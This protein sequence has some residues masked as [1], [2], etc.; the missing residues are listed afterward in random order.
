MVLHR[1]TTAREG[2]GEIDMEGVV[3]EHLSELISKQVEDYKLVVWYDPECAYAD[4]AASFEFPNTTI[5]RYQGSFLQLRKE[6]DHL[7]NDEEPPCLVI[8]VSMDQSMTHHALIELEVAGVVIQPGQQPPQRNTRLSIVA[9][10]ALKSVLGEETSNDVE[11]QVKEGKLTLADVNALAQKGGEISSGVISIIF[12]AGNPQEV[13]LAFVASDKFD[14]DTESKVAQQ[15]LYNLIGSAFDI[16]L[17]AAPSLTEARQRLAKHVLLTELLTGLAKESPSSLGSVK[18][19]TTPSSVD[20]CIRLATRWRQIRDYRE[21]YVAAASAVDHEYSLATIEYNHKTINDLETVLPIERA[22]L[23]HVEHQLVESPS[24]AL[25]DLAKSRL[26]RFWSDVM[27]SVQAHWAL[28]AAAAEVLLEAERVAKDLEKPP[29]TIP[30]FIKHYAE[31]G[32]PWCLLDTHHRHMETRW[33]N[34]DPGEHQQGLEKLIVKARQRYT[35]VGSHLSKLF[36]TQLSKAKHPFKG[37]RRQVEVYDVLIQPR[38]EEEKIAYLWVDALRFEMARELC[39]A[40]GED[41]K[42]EIEPAIAN[43][44]T[45]TEI[46]M[47]SLLPRASDGKV[48]SVGNGRLALDINGTVIKERKDRV[49]FLKEKAYVDFFEA[50]LDDLLPKPTKKIREGIKNAQLVLIT[51]QEID[52]LCEKDNITQARRQMD[53][54]LV[55]LRRGVRVL[56]DLGIQ[57]IVLAADHGHVFADEITEDMKIDAP[58]GDTADLHRRVWVGVGGTSEPSYVRFPLSKLGAESEFDIAAPFTLACFKSKGGARAYFHGGLSPQEL[59]IPVVTLTPSLHQ[60]ATS[61]ASIDWVL[62]PGTPKIT[63]R[64]FSIRISGRE[65][66]LNLFGFDSLKI[67]VE[68]RAKSK[69][70]SCPVSASYGFQNATGEIQ[71]RAIEDNSKRIDPN[72]IALMLTQEISQKSVS[73]ALLDASS[74]IELASIDK[75]EIAISF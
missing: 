59:I 45:I 36:V 15:E 22:L 67:R 66:G 24:G 47:A 64:F 32:I 65:Q 70:V 48:V 26:A 4:A 30:T 7:L 23:S 51:S 49:K 71:L 54:V 29:T 60:V 35:E 38:Q 74:G 5:A 12:G 73:V 33:Y 50:K 58:G 57:T 42:I 6:I 19:A 18:I 53:G 31:G 63:T 3:T 28:I 8:Y 56:A 62:T 72:T 52:E 44:P 55:D 1:Q 34:F 14:K 10:N 17:T 75:I 16:T 2:T 13:A 46:G 9:R 61:S 69:C 11:K 39:E 68:I 40:L 41:F 20:S 37:V 25:L 43:A 21:T 27:P